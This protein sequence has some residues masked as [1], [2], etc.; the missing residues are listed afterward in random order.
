[1]NAIDIDTLAPGAA[2]TVTRPDFE[3]P[4]NE[5]YEPAESTTESP[6]FADENTLANDDGDAAKSAACAAPGR[7]NNPAN[8]IA[9]AVQRR[10]PAIRLMCAAIRTPA[11]VY[12]ECIGRRLLELERARH[13]ATGVSSMTVPFLYRSA[14]SNSYRGKTPCLPFVTCDYP[15]SGMGQAISSRARFATSTSASRSPGGI[16]PGVG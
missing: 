16:A 6:A 14:V 3:P 15:E 9:A 7:T 10:L 4:L 2:F 12:V 5:P 1:L 11:G 13:D 8:A